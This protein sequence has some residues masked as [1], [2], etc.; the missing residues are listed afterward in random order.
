LSGAEQNILDANTHGCKDAKQTASLRDYEFRHCEKI[1]TEAIQKK[2]SGCGF[3][4]LFRLKLRNDRLMLAF[5]L[6]EILITLGI[7]GVVA[8]MTIPTLIENNQ[9]AQYV[10]ALKKVYSNFNQV[11]VQYSADKGCVGDL[12]CTNLFHGTSDIAITAELAPYFNIAKR[13][14]N[15][16]SG[17]FPANVS[18]NFDGSG[19]RSN[20][21]NTSTIYSTFLTTD[22]MAFYITTISD[23]CDLDMSLDG[24]GDMKQTCGYIRVDVNGYKGPNNTGRDIFMFWITNGRGPKLS[25]TGGQNGPSTWNA[26]P[27]NLQCN[28]SNVSG[29]VCTARVIEEGWQ[30]NY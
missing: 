15:G 13:C 7:I 19:A 26:N 21:Y 25:P 22:G 29:N 4:G 10:T 28:G 3:L 20:T 8:A 11:L 2:D 5:T 30:M 27:A 6:A 9:K 18:N 12:A 23:N 1:S 17:C 14:G 16:V 24:T